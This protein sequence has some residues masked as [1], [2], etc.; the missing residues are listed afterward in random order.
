MHD[1]WEDLGQHY[2]KADIIQSSLSR[3]DIC[4]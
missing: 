2:L 1:A 4:W 3:P